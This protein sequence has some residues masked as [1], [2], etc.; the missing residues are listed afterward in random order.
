MPE[1]DEEEARQ[2][3]DAIDAKVLSN[4]KPPYSILGGLYDCLKASSGDMLTATNHEA[5]QAQKL[6]RELEGCDICPEGV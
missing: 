6:F 3:I 2:K 1:M 4:R 5:A